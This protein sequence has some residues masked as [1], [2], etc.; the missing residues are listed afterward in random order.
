GFLLAEL[1]ILLVIRNPMLSPWCPLML[2]AHP[3]AETLFSIYRRR[4][5]RGHHP[6]HPDALHLHQL[7]YSRLVR[8]AGG[9]RT[10]SERLRRNNRVALFFWPQTLFAALLLQT[11]WQSSRYPVGF[12]CAYFAFYV[13]IYG[14]L[15]S[16]RSPRPLIVAFR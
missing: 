13:W 16:W 8:L 9:S 12:T 2:M 11:C 15:V 3:V 6:G 5:H 4:I 1:G 14:R 10:P 7:V